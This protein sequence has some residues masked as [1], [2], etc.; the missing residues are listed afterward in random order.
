MRK[1]ESKNGYETKQPVTLRLYPSDVRKIEAFIKKHG[2]LKQEF[3]ETGIKEAM[4]KYD[5]E[6]M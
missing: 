1:R 2:L 6:A 5:K 4:N 3:F